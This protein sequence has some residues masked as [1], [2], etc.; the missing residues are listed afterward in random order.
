[1]AVAYGRLSNPIEKHYSENLFG[2][3][4]KH[5]TNYINF[6]FEFVYNLQ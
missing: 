2:H 4:R 6:T 1:M 5:T 3:S